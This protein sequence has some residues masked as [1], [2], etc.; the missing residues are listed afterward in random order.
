MRSRRVDLG[1]T[2][3]SLNVAV[4]NGERVAVRDTDD[5]KSQCKK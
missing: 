1:E 4:L 3:D 5:D 2:K